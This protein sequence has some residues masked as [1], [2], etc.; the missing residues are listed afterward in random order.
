[1]KNQ[2]RG[3]G[4]EISQTIYFVAVLIFAVPSQ[5]IGSFIARAKYRRKDYVI[6]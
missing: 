4:A 6:K 1:M 5:A 2:G 3:F